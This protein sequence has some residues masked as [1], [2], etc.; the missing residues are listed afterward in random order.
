MEYASADEYLADGREHD[1]IFLDIE[2]EGSDGMRS[3]R[4]IWGMDACRQTI[5]VFVTDYEKYVYGAF[6]VGAFQYLVKPVGRNLQKC[7]A[8]QWLRFIRIE[9][10]KKKCDPVCG[11]NKSHTA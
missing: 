9:Q 3:A 2:M 8:G 11:R 5:I 6:D 1:L 7:S 4:P 10:G